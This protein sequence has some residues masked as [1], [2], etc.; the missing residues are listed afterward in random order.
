MSGHLLGVLAEVH[1]QVSVQQ[2]TED[3]LGAVDMASDETIEPISVALRKRHSLNQ[4]SLPFS[5]FT[6]YRGSEVVR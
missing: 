5:E 2:L 6:L 1:D 4:M 3:D